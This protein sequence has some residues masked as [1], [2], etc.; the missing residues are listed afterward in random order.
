[1]IKGSGKPNIRDPRPLTWRR[2][3][4]KTDKEGKWRRIFEYFERL[5][6]ERRCVVCEHPLVKPR[7][8]ARGVH[9]NR[10]LKRFMA[11]RQPIDWSQ[12]EEDL[13]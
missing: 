11:R 9:G 10:C 8:K 5:V 12:V 1:M 3:W 4:Q 2:Y 6:R 7:D 13:M